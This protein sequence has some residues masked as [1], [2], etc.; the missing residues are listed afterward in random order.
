MKTQKTGTDWLRLLTHVFFILLA[1]FFVIFVSHY[2]GIFSPFTD[3]SDSDSLYIG[4][5]L[6]FNAHLPQTY[7]DHTGYIYTLLLAKYLCGI[8]ALHLISVDTLKQ[9]AVYPNFGAAFSSLVYYGRAFSMLE[10]VVFVICFYFGLISLRVNRLVCFLLSLILLTSSGLLIQALILRPELMSA[11]F[12]MIAFFLFANAFQEMRSSFLIKIF[13]AAFFNFLAL[14]AKVQA[15]FHFLIIPFLAIAFVVAQAHFEKWSSQPE[16]KY[17]LLK[18]LALLFSVPFLIEFF[19]NLFIHGFHLYKLVAPLAIVFFLWSLHYFFDAKK[20][21]LMAIWYCML[22]GFSAALYMNLFHFNQQN[23]QAIFIYLTHMQSFASTSIQNHEALAFMLGF[24][25]AITNKFQ[26][27]T[28]FDH[29]VY[30]FF[31][32]LLSGAIYSLCKKEYHHALIVLL[33]LLTVLFL[34]AAFSLRYFSS[35]YYIYT[36]YLY[37]LGFA[38]FYVKKNI[39]VL[40]GCVLILLSAA[41]ISVSVASD[42]S[43][44]K[45]NHFSEVNLHQKPDRFCSLA[46][47]FTP[48]LYALLDKDGN[49]NAVI[50]KGLKQAAKADNKYLFFKDL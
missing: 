20:S 48:P 4:Q 23:V 26:L 39:G 6:L 30:I 19:V 46:V 45:N 10:S 15:I 16:K 8:R 11:L 47:N 9:I 1:I 35:N 44:I 49:C 32:F 17:G 29:P 40:H 34:E 2:R 25:H 36:E 38:F 7:F 42:L 18:A 14:S 24:Y 13:F 33:F 22:A 21:F 3:V 37:L 43:S 5:I 12:G 28:L 50:L 27:T 31:F 41:I